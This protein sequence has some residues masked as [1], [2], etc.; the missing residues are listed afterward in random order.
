MKRAAAVV[1]IAL[2]NAIAFGIQGA[3]MP[4]PAD[5][6]DREAI[7]QAKIIQQASRI[8][9]GAGVRIERVDGTRVDGLFDRVNGDSL[10]ILQV[11]NGHRTTIVV[12]IKDVRAVSLL[13]GSALKKIAVASGVA[14]AVLFGLCLAAAASY[15]G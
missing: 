3:A 1:F 10:E 5:G 15:G 13:K 9:P 7:R 4:G 14:L 11:E 12:P 6:Q 8:P 2:I